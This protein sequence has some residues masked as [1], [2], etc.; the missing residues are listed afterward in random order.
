[1][2][3]KFTP[4]VQKVFEQAFPSRNEYRIHCEANQTPRFVMRDSNV[5]FVESSY[6]GS[7]ALKKE[8]LDYDCLVVNY[9][10]PYFMEGIA[11]SHSD[12]LVVWVGWGGDYCNLIAPYLGNLLLDDTRKLTE[13]PKSRLW[14][15]KIQKLAFSP[16]AELRYYIKKLGARQVHDVIDQID[17]ICVNPQEICFIE[18][19]LPGFK[20]GFHNMSH[21]SAEETFA[22]GPDKMSGPDLLLGNSASATNNHLELFNLL[23]KLDLGNRKLIAPLNYGDDYYADEI[24]RIGFKYFGDRFMPIRSFMP[25]DEYHESISTCGT[26]L[27]NHVRQQ[28]GTTIATAL[29]KGA[30]VY[31]RNE[32]PLTTFYRNMG[33]RLYS[34]QGD[35]SEGKGSFLP[36]SASDI[37]CNKVILAKYWGHEQAV[38]NVLSL[39]GYLEEKRD[40]SW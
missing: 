38:S 34:I 39:A 13:S 16:I 24:S 8:L 35:L 37:M 21:Y 1:V 17:L 27:M 18:K 20:G 10:H 31:L 7:A 12:M 33:V 29:Y 25:I 3:D 6:W 26:V 40:A 28:A 36:L 2:D 4:F 23:T 5:R 22:V 9:M 19:A 30:K 15:R 14:T 11:S 32:N